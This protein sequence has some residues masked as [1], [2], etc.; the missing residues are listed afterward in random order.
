M[1]SAARVMPA[2]MS[3]ARRSLS[4]GSK[5]CRKRNAV[6]DRCCESCMD[7]MVAELHYTA[8]CPCDL[9]LAHHHHHQDQCDAYGI[10]AQS[11]LR[12]AFLLVLT[13]SRWRREPWR[14][15]F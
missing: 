13:S 5:P 9:L 6:P 14:A 12:H 2:T 1:P 4:N 11:S 10:L 7:V 3:G 8:F 15:A